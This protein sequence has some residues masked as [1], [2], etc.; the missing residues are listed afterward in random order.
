MAACWLAGACLVRGA[1]SIS[2]WRG[3]GGSTL[4]STPGNWSFGQVPLNDANNT[5]IVLS[6]HI[7]ALLAYNDL[8]DWNI[9]RIYF[10]NTPGMTIAGLPFNLGSGGI[11]SER[12]DQTISNNLTFL[13]NMPVEVTQG[14][15]ALSGILSEAV[16]GTTLTK[17]G[18]G[19]L[20]LSGNN[21][22]TGGLFLQGGTVMLENTGAMG[23]GAIHF[24]GGVLRASEANP[25]D[26]SNRFSTTANQAY[27]LDTNG[28]DL[29]VATAL[30]SV[31]GSLSKLGAGTLTLTANNTYDGGTVVHGGTLTV[32]GAGTFGSATGPITLTGG[33][34]DLAGRSIT[35]GL[36]T[37]NGGTLQNGTVTGTSY[38]GRSGLALGNLGGTGSLT[39]T[40]AGTLTLA[41]SNSYTGGTVLQ[42]GVLELAN[43]DALGASGTIS[44]AGGTLRFS[45]DNTA[46]YSARFSTAPGQGYIFDTNN[47]SIVLDSALTS[48]GGTLTKLG[49]GTLTLTAT[50][51]Y[52]GGTTVRAGTLALTG[53]GTLGAATGPLA[54]YDSTIDLGGLSVTTGAV[55]L[56]NATLQNGAITAPSYEA[57]SGNLSAALAGPGGLLKAAGGEVILT[58]NNTYAGETVI[59]SGQLTLGSAGA[60]GG[61]GVIRFDGGT[62]RFTANNTS[63]YSGRF[64]TAANQAYAIDTNG[65]AVTFATGLS[66]SGGALVKLGLGNLTLTGANSYTGGTY[67]RGGTLILGSAEALPAT[68]A[69]F[70]QGGVLGLTAGIGDISHR[71]STDSNQAYALDTG[72]QNITLAT[73]FNSSGG[74]LRKTGEGT[75]TLNL[76]N[77]YSRGTTVD[78]G[79]LQLAGAGTLGSVF[80]NITIG[81]TGILDLGGKTLSPTVL[82]MTGGALQNGTLTGSGYSLEGGSVGANLTGTGPLFKRGN[83]SVLLTGNNTLNGN[84]IIEGGTLV[85]GSATALPMGLVLF[86]GGALGFTAATGDVSSRIATGNTKAYAFDTLGQN[87]TL[88]TPFTGTGSSLRK[89]GDGVLTLSGT[90]TYTGATILQGGVLALASPSAL[91]ANTPLQFSGGMLRLAGTQDLSSRFSNADNQAYAI[92]TNGYDVT[93]SSLLKSSGGSLLKTGAGTL[94][95]NAFNTYTGGTTVTGGTLLVLPTGKMGASSGAVTIIGA[96][97]DMGGVIDFAGSVTLT[98]STLQNGPLYST[99][100]ITISGGTILANAALGGNT[101][102]ATHGEIA[103]GLSVTNLTKTT[104]GTLTFS[105]NHTGP[106]QLHVSGGTILVTAN[107][108]MSRTAVYVGGAAADAATFRVEGGTVSDVG[109]AAIG[110]EGTGTLVLTDNGRFN[111]NGS[112]SILDLG[113]GF[114][115]TGILKIGTGGAPGTLEAATV[116][117]FGFATIEFNHTGN[118]T[119]TPNLFGTV[120]V[121]KK[122]SGT[123]TL[124]GSSTYH[125]GTTIEAGTL[126]GSTSSLWGDVTNQGVLTFDQAVD[127]TYRHNITGTGALTKTGAGTLTLSGNNTYTG[128][129][130]VSAGTL[131]IGSGTALGSGNIVVSSNATLKVSILGI[132]LKRVSGPGTLTSSGSDYSYFYNGGNITL[133]TR[134]AGSGGLWIG[135]NGTVTLAGANTYTG[136]TLLDS[137]RIVPLV[138]EAFGVGG[139]IHLDGGVLQF[140]ANNTT[141]YSSRFVYSSHYAFDTGG[142]QVTLASPLAT[143]GA[144]L[145]KYGAGTLILSG[146]NTYAGGTTINQGTLRMAHASA[147]GLGNVTLAPG[148]TLDAAA[149]GFDLGRLSGTGSLTTSGDLTFTGTGSAIGAQLTGAALKVTTAGVLTLTGNNSFSGGVTL[150]LGTLSLGSEGALGATGPIVFGAGGLR[151]S[152]DNTVD[153]SS[154]F[155]SAANQA[156]TVDTNGQNITFASA[157]TSAGGTLRKNGAGTL[158]LSAANT[159]TGNT[160]VAGGLLDVVTGGRIDQGAATTAVAI[161]GSASAAA[162]LRLT[163]GGI[164]TTTA[165]VGQGMNNV[166]KAILS[167]GSWQNAGDLIVGYQGG[168]GTLELS[169]GSLVADRSHIGSLTGGNGTVTMSGGQWT[170]TSLLSLGSGGGTGTLN[171]TGGQITSPVVMIGGGGSAN[172]SGGSWTVGQLSVG[173]GTGG[174]T[175]TLTDSGVINVNDGA[176]GIRL[177]LQT[178]NPTTLNIGAGGSAGTL[179]AGFIQ[180]VAGTSNINFNHNG[181]LI[182]RPVLVGAVSVNHR[183]VGTTVLALGNDYTGPTTVYGGTLL[184][185]PSSKAASARVET[186][187]KLGGYAVFSGPGTIAMG[188]MLAPFTMTF[189]AGLTLAENSILELRL[190]VTGSSQFRVSSGVLTGPDSG[191]VLIRL[192]NAGDFAAGTYSL[193]NATGATLS[194][195]SL[196][197]F[198][199]DTTI[200]G[201]NYQL[202]FNN[203]LLQV[204]ASAIPEPSAYAALAGVAALAFVVYRRRAKR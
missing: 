133:D 99:G 56:A 66:S 13:T 130:T 14:R 24:H 112:G 124:T 35:A 132:D 147:L 103:G 20:I 76:A 156:I 72:G 179:N 47:Q 30:T 191:S 153:Y 115:A 42:E 178:N 29:E 199:L 149:Y 162:T 96:T 63:D 80:G 3:L 171:L 2:Y 46:D 118:H 126:I 165:S 120:A 131:S 113:G 71:F 145:T 31:G 193:L 4:W 40:T 134:L 27:A 7:S 16:A 98:N 141:D 41:G 1:E 53:N 148:A 107:A 187:A 19:L 157:L 73:A 5:T 190:G 144:L 117:G 17:Y 75:L 89:T 70:F 168:T 55:I 32:S 65:R 196:S 159:Y 121:I 43:A 170:S 181:L 95:L 26:Y 154:R 57:S 104:T 105:G 51:T 109:L 74:S 54:A 100:P 102:I 86:E 142:Q 33:A 45:P 160:T 166:G 182:L 186:G 184:L 122:G 110:N 138:P 49:G 77:T 189:N 151:F 58:G 38:D 44:L 90:N 69:I 62:L 137:G 12:G 37:F 155:T 59:R 23:T 60:L 143:T 202:A 175:L 173:A 83:G 50:N 84:L 192:S 180:G 139:A 128:N 135:T 200:P 82:T 119:F 150:T 204:T 114:G 127:D 97:L 136:P 87:V 101:A 6:P 129:T 194:N 161:N 158:T 172:V 146:S 152:A 125:G 92:D 93:F 195:L 106:T 188:G 185:N 79:T 177:G 174:G 123:T 163:G 167:S 48:V 28:L 67:L 9:N 21:T 140:G 22:F 18:G 183:G 169:G 64:S 94:T 25:V 39:K 68:G 85:L 164:T 34:L 201:F 108:S 11:L 111:L 36:V 198:K 61:G 81:G 52:D 116:R 197:S 78:G 8:V 10:V 88:S 176:G 15:V 203:N 91:P